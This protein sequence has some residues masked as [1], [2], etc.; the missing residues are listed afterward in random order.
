MLTKIGNI[1]T[2]I[3]VIIIDNIIQENHILKKIDKYIYFNLIYDLVEDKYCLDSGFYSKWFSWDIFLGY[4]QR[5][6]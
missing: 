6:D 1:Q 5:K 2:K 3:E 4:V